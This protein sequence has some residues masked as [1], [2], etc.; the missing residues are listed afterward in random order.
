MRCTRHRHGVRPAA[1]LLLGAVAMLTA[2]AG[3]PATQPA[4]GTMRVLDVERPRYHGAV[5]DP[6][7]KA[8]DAWALSPSQVETFFALAMAYP[9]R[10]Y[11]Q[12]YQVGCSLSG[13]VHRDGR[14]WRFAINGGGTATLQAGDTLRHFGCSAPGCEALLLLPSD[15]MEPD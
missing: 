12:F 4:P 3:T 11:T 10:P 5:G 6:L 2:C 14:E 7:E 9:D 15:G 13:R 1:A 8:C